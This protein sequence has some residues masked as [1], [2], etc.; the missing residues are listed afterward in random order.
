MKTTIYLI[1]VVMIE[2]FLV[3]KILLIVI[4]KA[5]MEMVPKFLIILQIN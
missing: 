4:D 5:N 1:V 3:V 2:I